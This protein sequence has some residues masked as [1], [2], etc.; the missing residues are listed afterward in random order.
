MNK[1]IGDGL[2]LILWLLVAPS[3]LAGHV[4]LS[5]KFDGS[6]PGTTPFPGSCDTPDA[7]LGY[8]VLGPVQVSATGT[9]DIADASYQG[10]GS[11]SVQ[12]ALDLVI[13]LYDGSFNPD[14]IS[15]NLVG[16]STDVQGD[17]FLEENNSYAVVAQHYCTNLAGT[18]GISIA[19]AGDITGGDAIEAPAYWSGEFKTDDPRADFGG[20]TG[21]TIY[22]SAGPI[23]FSEAGIYF[24]SDLT[25][26]VGADP[27]LYV[28]DAPFNPEDTGDNVV[29]IL[30]DGNRLTL[31]SGKDYYFVTHPYSEGPETGAWRFALFPPGEPAINMF[32]EDAWANPEI[33]FQ[34]AI[35]T[36]L[37][38][39]SAVFLAWYT[40]DEAP[41]VALEG[42]GGKSGT[43]A[44]GDASQRWLSA[45]GFYQEGATDV[46]IQWENSYGGAFNAST[47]PA[48]QDTDYGTGRLV[49]EDC[50][51][52]TI[53]Y[54]IPTGP[55]AGAYS[56]SRAA[57]DPLKVG[58]CEE[59][60]LQPG[61][62]E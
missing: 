20:Q 30:D 28:Y 55:G 33:G 43:Q 9:Y 60:G 42:A 10:Q 48:Q 4:V 57:A 8:R 38:T 3:A 47:P 51:Q 62:I 49:I 15:E 22:N 45:L 41:S 44:V 13:R 18:F 39:Y 50:N 37:P 58:L 36:V 7:T 21:E 32:Y 27:V 5:G 46:E 11:E 61:V 12:F 23:Q 34:G 2:M 16:T 56:V 17:V 24:Y 35:I 59:E 26:T 54:D 29:A 40:Y 52:V 53:E 14:S 1:R 31:D 19:G 6:E 25:Y